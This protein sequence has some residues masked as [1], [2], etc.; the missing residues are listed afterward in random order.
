M[1]SKSFDL[2]FFQKVE[3]GVNQERLKKELKLKL[4]TKVGKIR[5][6]GFYNLGSRSFLNLE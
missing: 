4:R 5:K 3:K 1:V 2:H 6:S